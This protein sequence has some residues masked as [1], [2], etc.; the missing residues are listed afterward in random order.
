MASNDPVAFAGVYTPGDVTGPARPWAAGSPYTSALKTNAG[1][2]V[3]VPAI[4]V[5]IA[6]GALLLL[7]RR[8]LGLGRH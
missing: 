6:V 5:V 3:H 8:R 7:E 2:P 1:A 4:G